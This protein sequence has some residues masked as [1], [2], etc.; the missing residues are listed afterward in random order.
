V[1]ELEVVVHLDFAFNAPLQ[2]SSFNF[3][4]ASFFLPT[5]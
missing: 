2:E 3:C 1:V 5:T 4:F